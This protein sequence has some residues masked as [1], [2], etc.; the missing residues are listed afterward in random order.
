MDVFCDK[1]LEKEYKNSPSDCVPESTLSEEE[2]GVLFDATSLDD[3]MDWRTF[4]SGWI[5]IIYSFGVNRHTKDT[6]PL[7]LM[8]K[9]MVAS[10]ISMLFAVLK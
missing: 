4:L 3:I 10:L 7:K 6:V 8:E 2:L 1:M 9:H 5:R